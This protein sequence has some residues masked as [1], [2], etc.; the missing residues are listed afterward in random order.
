VFQ[1]A[2][3]QYEKA[4]SMSLAVGFDS[5]TVRRGNAEILHR[6]SVSIPRH[7]VCAV[8]GRSG[9]GKTTFIKALLGLL[10]VAAGRIVT[11]HG[12]LSDPGVLAAHRRETAAV[13]QD[14]AL[15]DRLTTIENVQLGLAH[16]RSPWNP[17]PWPVDYRIAA[18]TALREV[19]MLPFAH[20]RVAKLSG[21]QRQRVGI[22]RALVREP[23][24]LV[25]DEPFSS[26]DPML[27]RTLC[28]LIRNNV[29]RLGA[30]AILVLHQIDLALEMSDWVVGLSEGQVLFCGPTSEFLASSLHSIFPALPPPATLAVAV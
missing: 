19:D 13:F 28:R 23:K 12:A 21:G 18:A 24:L 6:M 29:T 11:E 26:L 10:P 3:D 2:V 17:A 22:A 14:H 9:A 25:A 5:V 20:Q 7:C 15:I 30:T 8:L 4:L 1:C 27:T 16:L